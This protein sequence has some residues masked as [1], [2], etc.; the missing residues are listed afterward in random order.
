MVRVDDSAVV[1]KA[2]S[3]INIKEKILSTPRPGY[4]VFPE[5]P[6]WV[7]RELGGR[8]VQGL[9]AGGVTA[10]MQRQGCVQ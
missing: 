1:F 8:S 5:I 10:Q 9:P 6:V 7:V 4:M 3:L 2:G